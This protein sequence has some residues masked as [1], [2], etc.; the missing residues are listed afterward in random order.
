MNG[1]YLDNSATTKILDSALDEYIKVSNDYYENPSSLHSAGYEA[2]KIITRARKIVGKS[3][4]AKNDSEIIFT[5]GGTE[6]DNIAIL[7]VARALNKQGKHIITSKIEHHAVLDCCKYLESIGYDVTYLDVNSDGVID[8]NQLASCV[9]DDTIL[10][11]IMCVNNEVGA[12]QP[13]NEI[14]KYAKNAVIHTDAVQAYSKIDLSTIDA[15]LISVSAHKI[16]GPKGTGALYIKKGTKIKNISFGGGQEFEIR[17]GTL[18]TPAI[19]SFSK[20][21]EFI[22]DNFQ[23]NNKK[24]NELSVYFKEKLSENIDNIKFNGNQDGGIINV[25][26]TGIRG[27]VLLHYLEGKNIFVSTGSACNAKSTKISYV[28]ESM[29]IPRDIAE[30]AIRI[31]LS[32]FNTFDEIDYAVKSIAEGVEFLRKFKRR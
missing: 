15:D 26:F 19:A 3:L 29:N 27:E 10:I 21:V 2:E 30:G 7:G 17:S 22:Q 28:L 9:R 24:L 6:S 31:S 1:I 25:S 14:R 23:Q 18:N 20:A 13:I 11:S 5:S 12:I 8:M 16:F 32:V 4:G